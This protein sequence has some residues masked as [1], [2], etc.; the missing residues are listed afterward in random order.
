M[1]LNDMFAT[2]TSDTARFHWPYRAWLKGT[3]FQAYSQY[4]EE[5]AIANTH[6]RIV[7]ALVGPYDPLVVAFRGKS[8][9]V[10]RSPD[11][12]WSVNAFQT[13]PEAPEGQPLE[14]T[15]SGLETRD[16]A[17]RDA[18]LFL[19]WKTWDGQ[20]ETSTILSNPMDQERFMEEV[21]RRKADGRAGDLQGH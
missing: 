6:R 12:R 20:E 19:A 18:R 13:G 17:E 8:V 4:S 11:H 9:L 3:R 10:W 5:D 2:E 1:D 7:R 15:Y 16:E 14:A 21:R